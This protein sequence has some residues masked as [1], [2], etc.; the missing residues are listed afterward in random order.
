MFEEE[1]KEEKEEKEEEKRRR[2]KLVLVCILQ[3]KRKQFF[4][5]NDIQPT[6]HSPLSLSLSTP[7]TPT[8][9][10]FSHLHINQYII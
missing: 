10:L 6:Q 3:K 8:H 4:N 7:Y 9:P 2:K 1:K 5:D